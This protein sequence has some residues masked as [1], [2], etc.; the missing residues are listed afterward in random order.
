MVLAGVR[1]RNWWLIHSLSAA[2]DALGEEARALQP[3]RYRQVM[4]KKEERE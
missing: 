4:L 2:T 1:A 3:L